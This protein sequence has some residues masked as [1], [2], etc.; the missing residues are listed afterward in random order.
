MSGTDK[1]NKS[2]WWALASEKVRSRAAN[3]HAFFFLLSGLALPPVI[4]HQPQRAETT[5]QK[6]VGP[7]FA[8]K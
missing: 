5:A 1:Y 2:V 4:P 7:G 3:Q 6:P 8:S